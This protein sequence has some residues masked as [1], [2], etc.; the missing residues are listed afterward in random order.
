MLGGM[1]DEATGPAHH[2]ED[3]RALPLPELARPGP[4]APA[5]ERRA[6]AWPARWRGHDVRRLVGAG[7]VALWVVWLAVLWAGQVRVVPLSTLEDDLEAGRVLS[8]REVVLDRHGDAP[9]TGS[10]QVAYT[11]VDDRGRL[12]GDP[13]EDGRGVRSLAYWVEG[14]VASQRAVDPG[15]SQPSD[16]EATVDLLRATGVTADTGFGSVFYG[17]SDRMGQLALVLGLVAF[18]LIVLGPRPGRGTRWFWFWL[19]WAPFALGVLAYA[20]VELVR[21]GGLRRPGAGRRRR[22]GLLGILIAWMGGGLLAQ[23]VSALAD[24]A[25]VLLV[26]P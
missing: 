5:G 12:T 19:L 9:W 3:S 4:G 6:D 15:L 18:G 23:V 21:P 20:V 14:P 11:D 1:G 7:L 22:P 24:L 2:V 16:P 25:P 13:E 8:Y 26:R 10:H 17:R